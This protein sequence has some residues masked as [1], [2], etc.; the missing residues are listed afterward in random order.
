MTQNVV[1]G[2]QHQFPENVEAPALRRNKDAQKEACR[3]ICHSNPL[4]TF[5]QSFYGEGDTDEL[6]CWA[7]TP[8]VDSSGIG[9]DIAGYVEY[10]FTRNSYQVHDQ[11]T[12]ELT[13]GQ[14]IQHHCPMPT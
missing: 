9:Q 7:E 14:F 11:D 5:W 12:G 8:G 4:C 6:G 10:P 13:G 1:S 3:V 2:L